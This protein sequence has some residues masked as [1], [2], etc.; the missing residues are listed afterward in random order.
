MSNNIQQQRDALDNK[1]AEM[2]YVHP[3]DT[4]N[5]PSTYKAYN[6]TGKVYVS[7]THDTYATFDIDK[8]PTEETQKNDICPNCDQKAVYSCGCPIGEMMCKNNH[9]WYFVQGRGVV[10]GDPHENE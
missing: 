1:L 3:E 2:G 5:T 10:I 8:T 9:M 4:D 6:E 7:Q